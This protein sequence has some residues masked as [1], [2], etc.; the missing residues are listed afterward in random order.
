MVGAGE[1]DA[2][3]PERVWQ[4]LARGLMEARPN[5]MLELLRGCR[6]PARLLPEVDRFWGV[7]HPPPEHH[8]EIDTGVHPIDTEMPAPLPS[9]LAWREAPCRLT[10]D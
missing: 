1:V 10:R 2:L 3:V 4:E 6:A 9:R 7:P 8:P 5:R